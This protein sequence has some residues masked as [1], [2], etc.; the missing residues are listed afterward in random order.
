MPE[1]SCKDSTNRT[2]TDAT[3]RLFVTTR[4]DQPLTLLNEGLDLKAMKTL[5]AK[6]D[7]ETRSFRTVIPLSSSIRSF[8]R[9]ESSSRSVCFGSKPLQP[10]SA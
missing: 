4:P 10:A 2:T 3:A 1:K 8:V 5:E 6:A 7:A 9:I